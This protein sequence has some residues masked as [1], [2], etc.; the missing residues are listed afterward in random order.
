MIIL[1]LLASPGERPDHWFVPVVHR[2]PCLEI[3]RVWHVRVRL[4]AVVRP[5]P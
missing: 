4:H 3:L 2:T 5:L 1:R